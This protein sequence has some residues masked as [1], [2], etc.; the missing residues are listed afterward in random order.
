MRRPGKGL[1]LCV[2]WLF[3]L[4]AR[5]GRA[6]PL[7]PEKLPE[8]R[9]IVDRVAVRFSSPET[10][11]IEHPRFI[12]ERILAFEARLDALSDASVG[13]T[14]SGRAFD[15]RNVKNALD[16]HIVEEMLATLDGSA[17]RSLAEEERLTREARADVEERV[18]G[19]GPI[20]MAAKE[21]GLGA[22]EV[23]AVFTRRARAA[24]YIDQ[25]LT[26]F[27]HP[28]EEALREVYRTSAHPFRDRPYDDARLELTRWFVFERLKV[29]ASAFLQTAR[30]R[31]NVV[32]IPR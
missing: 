7:A 2:F 28:E 10:G 17:S 16:R 27:L 20:G 24:A 31:L 22:E 19:A 1:A 23:E 3:G 15:E 11:G 9:A 30:A 18:G 26:R 13:G 21:E 25:A 32:V 8:A 12:A 4:G 29:W 5:S 14:P 6:A